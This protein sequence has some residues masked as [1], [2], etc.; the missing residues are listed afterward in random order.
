MPLTPCR[1]SQS[2]RATR[3]KRSAAEPPDAGSIQRLSLQEKVEIAAHHPVG[4]RRD[5]GKWHPRPPP[6]IHA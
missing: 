5:L 1:S 2:I 3:A 4:C 6:G